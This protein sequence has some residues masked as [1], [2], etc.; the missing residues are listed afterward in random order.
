M[1]G[2]SEITQERIQ[3]SL[4]ECEQSDD[5]VVCFAVESGSRAWGFP[6]KDSDYD[7][8]FIYVRRPE[9]YLCID[10]EA[11]RDVIERPLADNID[12]SGWDLR[13]ALKLFRKSNPPLME[14]LQC[15]LV[16]RERFSV[17]TRLRKLLPT[18]YSPRAAYFHYLHMAQ[19]N[20][21]EYLRGETVWLKKY[22][23]VL[24]P[25]MAV[26]WIEGGRGPVPMEFQTLVDATVRDSLVREAIGQ[27][28][29]DKAAGA[30]LDRGPRIETISA[31]VESELAR[32]ESAEVAAQT[33]ESSVA[34]LN[35]L[36]REVLNEVW[37]S[38]PA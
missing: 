8:R 29:A 11:R 30:E 32:F 16:Y 31:F 3:A 20:F 9:W 13:K 35:E 4:D 26:R 36:F 15:P 7:V 12:L 24:R 21:R 14:W 10:L 34:A 22:L 2:V 18:S 37:S 33:T 1:H 27:L 23:Y 28:L 38:P 17:A 6:S 19:G 5:V 25:L